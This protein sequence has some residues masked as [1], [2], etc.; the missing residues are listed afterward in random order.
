MNDHA[1]QTALSRPRRWLGTRSFAIGGL[2]LTA[3]FAA[4]IP[5]PSRAKAAVSTIPEAGIVCTKDLN[6]STVGHDNFVL[7]ARD[8][9]I[10]TPDGNSIYTWS[11]APGNGGFQYPGPMLCVHQGDIVTITL[12]NSLPVPTSL[13]FPAIENVTKDGALA[14]PSAT[15]LQGGNLTPAV[16]PTASA[17]YQFTA[18][19]AGTFLYDSGTNPELQQQMGL[20]GALIVRPK[21]A[22][23]AYDNSVY[24][25]NT[26][27]D[28]VNTQFEP[29][30]EFIHILSEI[31]PD[32][33]QCM[34]SSLR[35]VT[36]AKVAGEVF[37]TGCP[38]D[39]SG[40]IIPFTY[41]MTQYKPRYFMING[42]SFPDTIKPNES[43][44]LPSQPYSALVHVQPRGTE[45]GY[46]AAPAVVRYL[47]AG[48][49]SYPF[50]P[51]VENE[52]VV[53][54]DG[55]KIVSSSGGDITQDQFDIVMPPGGTVE[56]FFSWIDA[57]N[58]APTGTTGGFNND[59][60]VPIP[61]DQDRKNGAYWSGSPYLGYQTPP[62]STETN[63]NECGEYYNVAHSHALFQAT[64]YG[65][66][67]GG[68]LTMIRIDPPGGCK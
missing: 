43:E 56:A 52:R 8:G 37:N 5:L 63:F 15:D 22:G 29:D 58:W 2:V 13:L 51:H 38:T 12:K 32:L 18:D 62:K 46:D 48:P 61:A 10:L 59:I 65:A 4:T 7:T 17:T 42:R 3:A 14:L 36:H 35:G 68:M 39:S 1:T 66:S 24:D 21:V 6:T 55:R 33:H 49:V 53:G 60:G 64:N 54:Q 47:N 50:H 26:L 31:D 30:R 25:P 28:T 44:S 27:P 23:I 11:Y 9:Y 41:D 19:Q 57:E 34:E 20:I 67:M 16:A 40:T 45:T